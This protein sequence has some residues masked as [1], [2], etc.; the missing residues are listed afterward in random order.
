MGGADL[1]GGLLANSLFR[2]RPG[3]RI[4]IL[5]TDTSHIEHTD[6]YPADADIVDISDIH[7]SL[8]AF[9]AERLLHAVLVG[10]TPHRVINLNSLLC[11]RVFQRFG[12]RLSFSTSLYSCVFCWDILPSGVRVGF[13]T[14]EFFA[15]TFSFTTAFITDTVSFKRELSEVYA[16]PEKLQSKIVPLMMP[17]RLPLRTPSVARLAAQAT[18]DPEKR[19]VA[20]AGRLDRQKRFDLVQKVAT[21]MPDTQFHCWGKPLVDPF[22]DISESP[23]NI[24]MHPPFSSHDEIPLSTVGAWLFTSG[25]EGMPNTIVEAATLG[26]PIVATA[27]GGIGELIQP[28]TGWPIDPIAAPE[29]Y[30]QALQFVLSHPDEAIKRAEQ[31]QVLV[32]ETHSTALLDSTVAEVLDRE[33]NR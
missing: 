26:F 28:D 32:S 33:P 5:R 6:W 8:P 27:V 30:V 19:I 3:E 9:A 13:A 14:A 23:P 21:L 29:V 16:I 22:V 18:M 25:W 11:W 1:V 15:E 4:L 10:L 12:S 7:E 20:W 17:A 31:L 24:T 2:I